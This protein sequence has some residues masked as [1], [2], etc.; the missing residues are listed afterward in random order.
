MSDSYLK[1][2]TGGEFT[3]RD[4]RTWAGSVHALAILRLLAVAQRGD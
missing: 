2:A 1:E 4:F 3:A